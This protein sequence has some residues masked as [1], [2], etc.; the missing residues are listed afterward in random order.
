MTVEDVVKVLGPST[1]TERLPNGDTDYRWSKSAGSAGFGIRATSTGIVNRIWILNDERY[2]LGP[3]LR[4]GRTEADAR[5][6]LGH[7]SWV[8]TIDSQTKMKT[9]MY[10]SRGVW[11]NIQLDPQAPFYNRI[12]EIDIMH[13]K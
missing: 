8:V 9:L 10:E 3:R 12:F 7:P 11:V 1:T 5:A 4:V 13:P 6:I 2:V